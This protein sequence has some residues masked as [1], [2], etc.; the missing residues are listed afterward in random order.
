MGGFNT[1]LLNYE[2][3]NDTNEFIN[4]MVFH[5]LLSHILQTTRVTDHSE[6]I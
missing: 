3:H 5:H 6:T 2:S 1:N 4:S